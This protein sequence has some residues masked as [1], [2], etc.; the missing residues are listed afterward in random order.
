METFMGRVVKHNS[1]ARVSAKRA[2]AA[3]VMREFHRGELH[4]GTSG[5]IVPHDRP[6]IAKAIAMSEAGLSRNKKRRR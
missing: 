5:E 3:K 2:K 6:D 1:P 4:H